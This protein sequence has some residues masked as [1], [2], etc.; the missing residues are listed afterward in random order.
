MVDKRRV[1]GVLAISHLVLARD[2]GDFLVCAGEA[3]KGG[4]E[5]RD[6]TREL[7]DRVVFWIDGDEQYLHTLGVVAEPL[8]EHGE[9]RHRRRA[10]IRTVGEAEE[11][12]HD[13]ALEIRGLRRR[14]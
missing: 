8:H 12:D 2:R 9:F 6:K 7:L 13:L 14:S 3:D 1:L 5:L 10:D 4:M 11:H